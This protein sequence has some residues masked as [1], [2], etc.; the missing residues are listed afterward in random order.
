MYD[1][2]FISGETQ[3]F[4][5]CIHYKMFSTKLPLDDIAVV[6]GGDGGLF[7]NIISALET[8]KPSLE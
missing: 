7:G 6:G 2:M 8:F 4:G 5:I 3:Q 1:I